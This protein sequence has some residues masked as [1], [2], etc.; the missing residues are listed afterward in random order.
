M[1]LDS[2]QHH[3]VDQIVSDELRVPQLWDTARMQAGLA[4]YRNAYRS[5]LVDALTETYPRTRQWVGEES[6]AKAAAHHLILHPPFHWSLDLAGEGLPETLASLFVNDPEVAE[7]AQ[8]EWDMHVAFVASDARVLDGRS[9]AEV[10]K[11]FSEAAWEALQLRLHPSLIVRP[12]HSNVAAIW[13]AL[14]D[15]APAPENVLLDAP[16]SLLVWREDNRVAFRTVIDG[17]ATSLAQI[18][19]GYTFGDIC[20]Q[21]KQAEPHQDVAKLV[22]GYLAQWLGDGLIVGVG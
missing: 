13:S 9:F 4:I 6:F 11:S 19:D 5:R 20:E 17:E 12:I 21:L 18:A 22:G 10:T 2:C 1:R 8:L 15:E 7:L 16:A 3:F 14:T